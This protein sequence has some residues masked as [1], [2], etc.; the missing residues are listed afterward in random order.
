MTSPH[1]PSDRGFERS[2][3]LQALEAQLAALRPREDRLDRERLMFLAGQASVGGATRPRLHEPRRWAWPASLGALT[4]AAA[5]AIAMLLVR[6]V[7]TNEMAATAPTV[8][9][10]IRSAST[11]ITS[12]PWTHRIPFDFATRV[13]RDERLLTAGMSLERHPRLVVASAQPEPANAAVGD[14]PASRPTLTTRSLHEILTSS[15]TGEF[16]S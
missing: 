6:P 4:G 9:R 14:V 2:P 1:E 5:A 10:E 7:F 12:M 13:D 16:S 11:T 15:R 8:K 3:Q